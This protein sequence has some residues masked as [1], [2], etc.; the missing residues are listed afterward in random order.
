[1]TFETPWKIQQSAISTTTE[2]R[3]GHT[4]AQIFAIMTGLALL[5][6]T[7]VAGYPSILAAW[8]QAMPAL[9]PEAA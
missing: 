4:M 1:M 3:V 5:G 7:T 6:T 8:T 2:D 9:P